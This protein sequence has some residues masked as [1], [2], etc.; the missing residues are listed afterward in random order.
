MKKIFVSTSLLILF[1]FIN[2][3]AQTL[4][5]YEFL[6]L[7]VDARSSAMAGSFVAMENDANLIFYNPAGISTITSPK[8]SVGFFKY[9]LDINSGNIVYAQKYKDYGYFGIGVRYVN[10]GTFD[11]FDESY[12]N[13]GTFSANDI[14]V[15]L[16]YSN[17]YKDI[18]NYGVNLKFIESKLDE[19]S[20]TGVAVDLGLLYTIP[21]QSMNIGV[22]VLNLGTQIKPY[23]DTREQLPLDVRV[24]FSKKLEHLPL[25]L[26]IGF[27]KLNEDY[28]KFSSRFRNLIIGGEF[29]LSDYVDLRVGYNN[30]QRQD[31][32]TGSSIGIGGFSAGLGIKYENY[33]F[34]YG[35]NSMGKI[36]ALHRVNVGYSFK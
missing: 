8:G 30:A 2:I 10:Y 5:V 6:K 13:L 33:T 24:G 9:L 7:D 31:L 22:S 17:K 3:N 18:I 4:S 12:T 25:T 32:Q 29:I 34:D 15:S 35:F 26:N 19:F 20:S 21:E 36:G 27:S 23:M 1:S 28:D 11:K 14:S 16:G